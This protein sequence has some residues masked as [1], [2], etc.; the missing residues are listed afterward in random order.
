LNDVRR[1]RERI[2][3]L[4][5]AGVDRDAALLRRLGLTIYYLQGLNRDQ[6][7]RLAKSIV[8]Q[9]QA[10]QALRD[11]E[12]RLPE[13]SSN[14]LLL[15]MA[16]RLWHDSGAATTRIE[17]YAAAVQALR[18]RSDASLSD[19]VLELITRAALRLVDDGLYEADRYWWLVALREAMEAVSAESVFEL[20]ISTAEAAVE[21]GQAIG[22]LRTSAQG[23]AL[24]FLH[25]SFR[26]FLVARALERD[27]SRIPATVGASWEPSLQMLAEVAG[28]TPP[29]TATALTSIPLAGLLAPLDRDPAGDRAGEAPQLV[30][31]LLVRHIGRWPERLDAEHLSVSVAYTPQ[32]RYVVLAATAQPVAALVDVDRM[33]EIAPGTPY[34]FALPPTVGPLAVAYCV[35]RELVSLTTS[36]FALGGPRVLPGNDEEIATLV[37]D[38]FRERQE[39]L[40]RYASELFPTFAERLVGEIGWHGLTARLLPPVAMDMGAG[41][42]TSSRRLAYDTRTSALDVAVA[43]EDEGDDLPQ[44]DEIDAYLQTTPEGSA[45]KALVDELERLA[46]RVDWRHG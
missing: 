3:E 29:L 25:D 20:D 10:E 7:Q 24:G 39:A 46:P 14:P 43:A 32:Y 37:A 6:A 35:W 41:Y 23:S 28:L 36:A 42:L 31:D 22:L 38:D 2:P 13:A 8:G 17:L 9:E 5:L 27:P 16:L 4:M 45:L 40:A 19:G 34:Q 15:T 44:R 12:A 33:A 30:R 26:D 11:I 18:D 1:L 21:A